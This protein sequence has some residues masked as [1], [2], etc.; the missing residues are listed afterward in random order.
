MPLR[1]GQF[2]TGLSPFGSGIL[3]PYQGASDSGAIQPPGST[4]PRGGPAPGR[5]GGSPGKGIPAV[6]HVPVRH[7]PKPGTIKTKKPKKP[8]GIGVEA[9]GKAG[10]GAQATGQAKPKKPKP[11]ATPLGKA[12][13]IGPKGVL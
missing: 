8:K 9:S 1:S 3:P 4:P 11:I 6:K 13:G 12:K 7:I 5:G 10:V 2:R